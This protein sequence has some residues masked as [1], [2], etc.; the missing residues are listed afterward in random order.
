MEKS[1][2]KAKMKLH[3]KFKLAKG[4]M[5]CGTIAIVAGCS[6][7]LTGISSTFAVSGGVAFFAYSMFFFSKIK[8]EI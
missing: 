5:W 7:Y 6:D 2:L 1:E 3:P 4:L 8:K